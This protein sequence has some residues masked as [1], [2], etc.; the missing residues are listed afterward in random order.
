MTRRLNSLA[1]LGR[2]LVAGAVLAA[3]GL[4]ALA[5]DWTPDGPVTIEIGFGAGGSTDAIGRLVAA[6]LKEQTGWNVIAENKPGGGGMAM[7]SALANRQA[8]GRTVGLGVSMPVMVN[9]VTRPDEVPFTLDSFAY[10]GTAARAQL[11]LVARGDAPFDDIDGMVAYAREQ[12]GMPVATD[13]KPQVL[14]MQRVM[15]QTGAEFQFLNTKSSAEILKLMLGGQTMVGFATGTHLPYLETGELKMLASF[16]NSRHDYAPDTPTLAEQGVDVYVDP[17]FYFAM[18]ADT[19]PEAQQALA[20]ALAEAMATEEVQTAV[21]NALS[22]D[23]NNLGPEGT[24]QMLDDGLENTR[25][26]FG[27]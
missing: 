19:A 4:A 22:V 24:R 5:Q 15:D 27:Q 14:A 25:K 1:H 20:A 3:S 12:G 17:W 6:R 23:V 2:A 16:N 7:F 9:L 8:D 26:L 13:A 11:A 21:R 10:L 18:S